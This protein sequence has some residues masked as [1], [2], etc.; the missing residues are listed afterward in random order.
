MKPI[1]PNDKAEGDLAETDELDTLSRRRDRSMF[2]YLWLN[3][4]EG[5]KKV[6]LPGFLEKR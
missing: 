1:I 4:R 2:N 6:V 5:S 3:L